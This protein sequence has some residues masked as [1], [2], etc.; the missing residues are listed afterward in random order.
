MPAPRQDKLNI[1]LP[2]LRCFNFFATHSRHISS[3]TETAKIYS[4]Q[5]LTM[6]EERRPACNTGLAKVAVPFSADTPD[7]YRDVVNQTLVLRINP[8][9]RMVKIANF[10]KPE[11]VTSNCKEQ[12]IKYC[13]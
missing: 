7:S 9:R 6:T 11:N 4:G 13:I 5:G 3:W 12:T 8:P 1:F 10:A 2:S